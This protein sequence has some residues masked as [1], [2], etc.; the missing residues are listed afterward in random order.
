M[1]LPSRGSNTTCVATRGCAQGLVVLYCLID[2]LKAHSQSARQASELPSTARP[3]A[4]APSAPQ[5]PAQ[6][7]RAHR[8]PAPRHVHDGGL[9]FTA[10]RLHAGAG[11]QVVENLGISP[12]VH[13]R[14]FDV[15]MLLRCMYVCMGSCT[16]QHAAAG[17]MSPCPA[18]SRAGLAAQ[19]RVR[20]KSQTPLL[21]SAQAHTP[22]H[23][24]SCWSPK[25]LD[26]PDTE[27]RPVVCVRSMAFG[28]MGGA[29]ACA[30][31][32]VRARA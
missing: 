20:R 16:R 12:Y 21:V 22:A 10:A 4:A 3:P 6:P 13:L 24:L 27:S 8:V 32:Y 26:D 2:C 30:R 28:R 23:T 9:L 15:A 29:C 11:A 19:A 5:P 7:P 31:V 25:G 17:C 1:L 18:C 14:M